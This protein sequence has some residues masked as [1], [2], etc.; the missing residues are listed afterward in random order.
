MATRPLGLRLIIGYKIVKAVLVLAV[1]AY[2]TASSALAYREARHL[3]AL[4]AEHG[5]F[6]HRLA[7]WLDVH[8]TQSALGTV[9]VLALLDGITTTVEAA[10]LWSGKTW[11]EWLVIAG[12]AT[13]LPF[14][15]HSLWLHRHLGH[16]VVLIANT[17]IVIYL[18]VRRYLEHRTG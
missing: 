3:V 13:L 14:E 18:V 16:V 1:A 2:L 17:A 5:G 11:G 10:L 7:I 9:R 4:L 8:V 6:M 12:L 15:A